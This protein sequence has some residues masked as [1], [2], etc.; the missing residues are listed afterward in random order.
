MEEAI[1]DK[2]IPALFGRRVNEIERK[3]FALPV[4]YGGLGILNPVETAEREFQNSCTI[5]QNLTAI[6]E[7]QETDLRHYDAVKMKQNIKKYQEREG[8]ISARV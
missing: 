6:I 1:R 7:N 2:L 5:T 4:R 8:D 3:I